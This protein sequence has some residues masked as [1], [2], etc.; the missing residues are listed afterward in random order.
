LVSFIGWYKISRVSLATNL[1]KGNRTLGKS[2]GFSEYTQTQAINYTRLKLALVFILKKKLTFR[3]NTVSF[4]S[5]IFVQYKE[6]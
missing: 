1:A 6:I 3:C 5:F 2:E 4:I